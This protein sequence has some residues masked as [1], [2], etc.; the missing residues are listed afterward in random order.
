MG[1]SESQQDDPL[2]PLIRWSMMK[3]IDKIRYLSSHRSFCN[4]GAM[5]WLTSL[6]DHRIGVG[7]ADMIFISGY[8][9]CDR[10]RLFNETY[11]SIEERKKMLACELR[12]GMFRRIGEDFL[13]AMKFRAPIDM[14]E[15]DFRHK[16]IYSYLVVGNDEDLFWPLYVN[17]NRL[18]ESI[19]KYRLSANDGDKLKNSILRRGIIDSDMPVMLVNGIRLA[20]EVRNHDTYIFTDIYIHDMEH[21][22]RV[23]GVKCVYY[24]KIKLTMTVR[25]L[26]EFLAGMSGVRDVRN[27][28]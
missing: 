6:S 25:S 12:P 13:H 24:C 15:R 17:V 7:L 2:Y 20:D 16:C 21:D 10:E 5:K 27:E 18:G 11:D 26:F 14:I 1:A 4:L 19:Y 22:R 3:P 9:K 8:Y 28:L 23:E